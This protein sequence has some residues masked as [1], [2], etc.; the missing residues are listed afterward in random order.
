MH[1]EMRRQLVA[2]KTYQNEI[3]QARKGAGLLFTDCYAELQNQAQATSLIYKP[4]FVYGC[5]CFIS[6]YICTCV[7]ACLLVQERTEL[8]DMSIW[9]VCVCAQEAPVLV[10]VYLWF[11]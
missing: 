9:C 8:C 10:H 6:A 5:V 3:P 7:Y 11:A 2:L 1:T 4:M